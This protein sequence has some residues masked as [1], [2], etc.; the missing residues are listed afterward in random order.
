MITKDDV[1]FF[2]DNNPAIKISV[3][4]KEAG[5]PAST[6]NK[7]RDDV[8]NYYT[9]R[10]RKDDSQQ[11]ED[12]YIYGAQDLISSIQ[13]RKNIMIWQKYW[14]YLWISEAKTDSLMVH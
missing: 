5:I 14:V 8:K 7:A 3:I 11:D 6:I 4:E 12:D 9:D 10:L 2:L 1:Y 13:T